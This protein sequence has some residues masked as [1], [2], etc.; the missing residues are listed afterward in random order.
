MTPHEQDQQQQRDNE[1][2]EYECLIALKRMRLGLFSADDFATV[3]FECGFTVQ[4][5]DDFNPT[6]R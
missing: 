2:R 1:Q 4:Q 5:V 6:T 3:A